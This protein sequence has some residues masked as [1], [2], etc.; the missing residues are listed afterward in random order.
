MYAYSQ[1]LSSSDTAKHGAALTSRSVPIRHND[2][3]FIVLVL[4]M[5][6]LLGTP[7]A[8]S[9]N[10]GN[11]ERP[12]VG[13]AAQQD[14]AT[15]ETPQETFVRKNGGFISNIKLLALIATVLVWVF[16][17]DWINRDCKF[18]KMPHQVWNIV[19]VFPMLV[20]MLLVLVIPIFA[21]GLVLVLCAAM[22]PGV[23]Y[24]VQRN[25]KVHTND[26]VLTSRHIAAVLS[27]NNKDRSN[28]TESVADHGPP[29]GLIAMGAEH[30]LMNKSNL[31]MARQSPGFVVAR[32]VLY[33][34]IKRHAD[35]IILD[36]TPEI[37]SVRMEIDGVWH[38]AGNR[39]RETADPMLVVLKKVSNLDTD[40][41][42][43]Q[44]KG[45]FGTAYRGTK[46]TWNFGSQGT[47][48]GER[49][50]LQVRKENA[51]PKS[52]PELDMRPKL[53]EKLQELLKQQQGL[54]LFSALPGGGLSTTLAAALF[55][56]DRFTRHFVTF[57]EESHGEIEIDNVD[58]NTFRNTNGPSPVEALIRLFRTEPDAVIVPNL[59]NHEVIEILCEQ[60]L[61][62]GRLVIGTLRAKEAAE[63]LLRVLS[64]KTPAEPFAKSIQAVVNQRLIRKL[65]NACKEVYNPPTD[66]VEKLGLPT[67]RVDAFYREPQNRTDEEEVCNKCGGTGYRGRIAIFE[68]LIVDS[69][70]RKT[71]TEQPNLQQLRQIAQQGGN[72]TLQEEGIVLVARGITSLSELQRV[73]K[74]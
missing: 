27:G 52:L 41:R 1:S 24:T 7:K 66:L 65:C 30:D 10:Q 14:N 50:V 29:L 61:K 20:V 22:I 2:C 62:E 5:W 43:N 34:A 9:Q 51:K 26:Q 72:R 49:A 39:D 36:Y 40:D 68:F 46:Q 55:T 28:D 13:A 73:L 38:D 67:S 35:K 16:V 23:V 44:Q 59:N 17:A 71:L 6:L 4:L 32:E 12:A 57:E 37:V 3:G 64:L 69:R 60:V 25:T 19:V 33:D 70:M 58:V 42:R 8:W 56:A 31:L 54:L 11:P 21:V 48:K 15:E 47:K 45:N 53:V 18:A 63:V 74:Q